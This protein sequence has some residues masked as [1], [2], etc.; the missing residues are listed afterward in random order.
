M[1]TLIILTISLFYFTVKA[2]DTLYFPSGEI[3][4]VELISVNKETGLIKYKFG[5]KTQIRSIASLKSYSNHANVGE[6]RWTL[7][8]GTVETDTA[9]NKINPTSLKDPSK[10]AYGKFSIGVN[11]LSSISSQGYQFDFTIASNYNQSF[12]V[13]YNLNNKLGFRLPMRI[14]FN[15]IK[16]TITLQKGE[17]LWKHERDLLYEGGL[18]VPFMINDNRKITPYFMPGIYF[19]VNKRSISNYNDSTFISTYFPSPK[20]T[21]YRIGFTGG[22]QFNFSKHF[23]LNT[24]LGF[25]VNNAAVYYTNYW[26]NPSNY[27]A[28]VRKQLGLQAAI[29]LVY[30]FGGKL[31][32]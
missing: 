16:D 18:E 4:L 19:G 2:Q 10:Y 7:G 12:Y 11:L 9:E 14:G 8:E 23:Q 3:Q 21:Y 1:K 17:Y 28:Y 22:L 32:E 25:N 29:N 30:R 20:H 24:E 5:E 6:S 15:Q 13:Q 31:R 27:T 26:S